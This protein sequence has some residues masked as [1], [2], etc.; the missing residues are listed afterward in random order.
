[1]AY[2]TGNHIGLAVGANGGTTGTINTT[3]ADLLIVAVSEYTGGAGAV[4]TDSQSNTWT[5]TTFRSGGEAGLKI[6]YKQ[7]PA[8]SASHTFTISGT[9]SFSV[10]EVLCLAGSVAS[11]FDVENGNGDG[12]GGT[13]LST[14]SIT[15]T[16][17][18]DIIITAFSTGSNG[19]TYGGVTGY[20]IVENIDYG[21]GLNEGL[22]LA[23]KIQTTAGAENPTWTNS[24]SAVRAATITA[25][26]SST[27]IATITIGTRT[28]LCGVGI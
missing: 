17:D 22:A 18:N 8:T 19:F 12:A 15:P 20:T 6:Y 16:Q 5:A 14:N 10:V 4:L 28:L 9:L 7:A 3:A 1:M 25:F 13:S 26:K 11:P 2:T 27:S 23:Y 21:A 24:G